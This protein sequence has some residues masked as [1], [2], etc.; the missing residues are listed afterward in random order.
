M[1]LAIPVLIKSNYDNN[2]KHKKSKALTCS[3]EILARVF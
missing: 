3:V 2:N 1:K